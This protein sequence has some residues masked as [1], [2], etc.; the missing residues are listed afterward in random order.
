MLQVPVRDGTG[1]AASTKA[2]ILVSPLAFFTMG[3]PQA[4]VIAKILNLGRRTFSRHSFSAVVVRRSQG[5]PKRPFLF[6]FKADSNTYSPSLTLPVIQSF[7][8]VCV[9]SQKSL[10]SEKS[11]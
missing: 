4:V 11:S 7:G 6:A 2:V 10:E 5:L 3:T 1:G 8:I 9:Q